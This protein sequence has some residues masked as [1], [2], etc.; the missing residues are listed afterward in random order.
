[1]KFRQWAIAL[2]LMAAALFGTV[3]QAHPHDNSDIVQPT[4]SS[5]KLTVEPL[6]K[7][8]YGLV[9]STDFPAED[10]NIAICNGGIV[11]G[12]DGVL[13][14]DPFQNEALASL[15]FETVASFT[16]QPI[17]YVL[18]THYHFDH[19][20][21][22]ASAAALE[23]PIIGRGPIREFML[24]RNLEQ[25]PNAAPPTVVVS[26]ASDLWLGDR[27]VQLLEFDGHSGGTDLVAYVPDVD[28]LIAG[29]LLFHQRIPFLGDGQIRGWQATLEQLV[30]D[31]STATVLPGH[32]PVSD[33][34]AFTA[35]KGYLEA[36]ESW[37]VDWQTQGISQ[38]EAL[39]TPLPDA[40]GDYL[41]QGLFPGNLEVAYQQI[42]LGQ[43]DAAAIQRY[44]AQSPDLKAL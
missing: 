14:I 5:A 37:A 9:A 12:S 32:G 30:A 33:S 4:L 21:G 29:D 3:V 13:V 34:S 42:T 40:Y 19:S 22:N 31:Y 10:P 41:F 17:R 11:V 15:M 6:A 1:M 35:L 24:E 7:G 23:Y 20:G 44:Q 16:D 36:L 26:G 8:V 39:E 27:Q 43:A 25:D 2:L 18:N 28:V 38:A